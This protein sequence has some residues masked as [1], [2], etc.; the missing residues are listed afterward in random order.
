MSYY[1]GVLI[2]FLV[3]VF[4]IGVYSTRKNS[5]ENGD[6]ALGGRSLGP[7][8]LA[9]T[10][11]ATQ[12]SAATFIGGPGMCYSGGWASMLWG[13]ACM[14]PFIALAWFLLPR[15]LRNISER[16]GAVTVPGILLA[17]YKSSKYCGFL[18]VMMLVAYVP[19]I[20]AQISAVGIVFQTI[21]NVDYIWGILLFGGLVVIYTGTGG[22]L[23]V[24][25]T[26]FVQAIIMLFG[27]AIAAPAA[28]HMAGGLTQMNATL[29]AIDPGYMSPFG[30][31]DAWTFALI[32]SWLIYYGF[33]SLGQPYT[34]VRYL[35]VKNTKTFKTG[36]VC[37]IVFY[38]FIV[39]ACCL[40]G[41]AARCVITDL[42]NG[43]DYALVEMLK[44]SVHPI[45]GG[46]VVAAI[47]AACMS[48]VD[49]ALHVVGTA[50]SRDFYKDMINPGCTPKQEKR[51]FTLATIVVGALAL[52][53][54]VNPP[55]SVMALLTYGVA[56]LVAMMFM[57]IV[58]GIFW[59]RFNL[60]AAF[61]SS[62]VGGTLALFWFIVMG[63]TASGIHPAGVAIPAAIIVGVVVALVTK[64]QP[65]E[66]LAPFFQKED[67][68][69]AK[70]AR[71]RQ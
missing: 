68:I 70:A 2:L 38:A 35:S 55:E 50:I 44:I 47:F 33:Q 57:P 30:V 46:I 66:E 17:R 53:M 19:V 20:T 43:Q 58:A 59:K 31:G 45:V 15:K 65:E 5:S 36:Y 42:P 56:T 1:W 16:V 52:I 27:I 61:A 49:S 14:I 29:R 8:V 10:W 22:F 32:F 18:A 51:M 25:Y 63:G 34:I 7:F 37:M 6:M 60:K 64:P 67:R 28:V 41:L 4:I 26:D 54:A 13:V 3:A 24:C 23:A 9:A 62:I 69:F 39:L 48:T 40:V 11:A 12:M 21:F 71:D